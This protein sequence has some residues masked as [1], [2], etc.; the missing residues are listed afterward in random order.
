M[1]TWK[2]FYENFNAREIKEY[3]IFEHGRFSN[4]IK[5]L[6]KKKNITKEEFVEELRK[7][8]MWCFWSKCEY[9]V[10]VTGFPPYID[11]KELDRL[12]AEHEEYNT[13]WGHYPYKINVEP[14]VAE[15]IDIYDQVRLN[16]HVFAD[17]VWN[18]RKEL[19]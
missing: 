12:N 8:L 19:K 10:V 2:V 5:K 6:N 17:Y 1:L 15:K 13:K 18:N 3:D 14:D 16:W 4:E 7:N 11:K 9:E